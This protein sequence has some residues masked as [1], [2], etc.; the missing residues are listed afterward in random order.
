M[1]E[2][3]ETAR[4]RHVDR[5]TAAYAVAAWFVVQAASIALPAFHAPDWGMRLLIVV[6]VVG[7]PVT[8]IAT[9]F[10]G[11]TVVGS[12]RLSMGARDW[13]LLGALGVVL[14][15]AGWQIAVGW[16]GQDDSR[17]G[18]EMPSSA[19]GSIA[20]LPF[21]NTGG[22]A[23]KKYFSEGMSDE[24]IGLLARNPALRV[25]A[26]TSSYF[27]EGKNEDVREIARK[28]NVRSVLEGS[29]REDGNRV[30][31]EV[32]L[33][34][35]SDG[36]QLWSQSYDRELSDILNVQSDIAQ[37]I[38]QAL[39]PHLVGGAGAAVSQRAAPIDPAAYRMYL[40][41]EFLFATRSDDGL[42]RALDLFRQVARLA[43]D[44]ADGQAA[45]AY[46]LFII[47][48]RHPEQDVSAEFQ[49]ALQQA[50]RLDATNP[51]TLTV[52]IFDALRRWDWDALIS[53][54]MTLQRSG[55]HSAVGL[56]G[57][58]TAYNAFS[59]PEQALVAERESQQLDPLSWNVSDSVIRELLGLGRFDEGATA[60]KLS[61][62][63]FPGDARALGML[64]N[65]YALGGHLVQAR[66]IL[67]DLSLPGMPDDQRGD[68]TDAIALR[69]GDLAAVRAST[70]NLAAHYRENGVEELDVG[71]A[72]GQVYEFDRAMDWLE[73]GFEKRQVFFDLDKAPTLPKGLFATPR[74]IALTQRPE[75]AAW[76]AARA[77]ASLAF[78]GTRL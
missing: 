68:C 53:H 60:A 10:A 57:L 18:P 7:L 45:L 20:V 30:R 76:R 62:K 50:L 26:R 27:F 33:I 66:E 2:F 12:G 46:D 65:S 17:S 15:V 71:I 32:S 22:A 67:R 47:G 51:Q 25:A 13:A 4:A 38:A 42:A 24:L 43:P 16:E 21:V 54:A 75:F 69:D 55:R 14:V 70:E 6:A 35:A 5:W 58:A 64:C 9:W 11:R 77:R 74:W 59:F 72:F 29:V 28:L 44:F 23:E 3:L 73:R 19:N 1:R 39:L 8:A 31:I 34:N 78:F 48:A 63:S 61:L 36:Y 52:A 49:V 56:H 40:Q 41:G 37:A